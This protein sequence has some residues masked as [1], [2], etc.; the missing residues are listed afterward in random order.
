M[1]MQPSHDRGLKPLDVE[2]CLVEVWREYFLKE[3]SLSN[4]NEEGSRYHLMLK[5]PLQHN[6]LVDLVVFD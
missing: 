6:K 4:H 5:A 1:K 2:G 3:M